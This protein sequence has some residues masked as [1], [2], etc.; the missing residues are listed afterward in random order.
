MRN[1]LATALVLMAL[2]STSCT[3]DELSNI[4][5]AEPD[6]SYSLYTSGTIQGFGFVDLGLS[7]K[8]ATC[9][10][11][12]DS[13]DEPGYYYKWGY[14]D[15]SNIKFDVFSWDDYAMRLSD[16]TLTAFNFLPEYSSEQYPPD[17]LYT[18][19][20][21]LDPAKKLQGSQWR[22]PTDD[23]FTELRNNCRFVW[24]EYNG[25]KGYQVT[26]PNGNSIFIPAGGFCNAYGLVMDGT[27]G[28]LWSSSISTFVPTRAYE[29]TFCN[30]SINRGSVDRFYGENI[31]PVAVE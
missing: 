31:R 6:K 23:E 28:C 30:G 22:M 25:R 13:P 1:L 26:G 20:E 24:S 29:L 3:E 9:N 21:D 4:K 12:A 10:L 19:T 17:S 16:G 11:G 18:L 27:S 14:T 8:W 7:V 2:I 5:Q 15:P